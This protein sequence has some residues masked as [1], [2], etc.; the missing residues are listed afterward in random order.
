VEGSCGVTCMQ[1]LTYFLSLVGSRVSFLRD[2]Y[3]DLARENITY[4][5]T[6]AA[7]SSGIA[8]SGLEVAGVV[9]GALPLVVSA[10]EHYAK[11]VEGV[12]Q[13]CRYRIQLQI[14]ADAVKTQ[15]VI[16]WNT[17]EQLST[18][19]VRTEEMAA[20]MANPAAHPEIDVQLKKRLRGGY[21]VY[22]ANVRGLETALSAMMEKLKLGVDGKVGTA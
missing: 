13:Y 9:L 22:F 2:S 18:G 16:F 1:L 17:L 11:G 21:D 15:Q 19:I 14:L 20:F 4:H 12:I 5:I 10:L 3:P 6:F 7:C 8:M